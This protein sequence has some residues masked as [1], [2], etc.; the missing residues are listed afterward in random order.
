MVV[1]PGCGM[2]GLAL[3]RPPGGLVI[4]PPT[5]LSSHLSRGAMTSKNVDWHSNGSTPQGIC[6]IFRFI[7]LSIV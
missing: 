5:G 2:A 1:C 3:V 7:V 6:H 4:T